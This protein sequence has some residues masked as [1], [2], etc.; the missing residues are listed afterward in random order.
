MTSLV[1]IWGAEAELWT[2]LVMHR[3]GYGQ[4]KRLADF[5][6]GEASRAS[7]LKVFS[8]RERGL[9]GGEFRQGGAYFG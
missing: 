8:S 2:G 1:L 3:L 6:K 9:L 5:T 7:L 4:A